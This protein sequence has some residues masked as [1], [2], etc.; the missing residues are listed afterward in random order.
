[1]KSISVLTLLAVGYLFLA[2]MIFAQTL[3]ID[4]VHFT[5]PKGWVKTEKQGAVVF[6]ETDKAEKTFC[7]VTI[8]GQNASLVNPELD[9]ADKWYRYVVLPF[10]TETRPRTVTQA[11]PDGWSAIVGGGLILVGGEKTA[12]ILTVFRGFGKTASVLTVFNDEKYAESMQ[13]F[14]DDLTFDKPAAMPPL[15]IQNTV[16]NPT[17]KPPSRVL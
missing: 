12:A 4:G 3:T 1:M 8:Y 2:P 14:I 17:K 7:T 13:S 10:K 11:R 5:P 16:P 9:F 6:T 15:P